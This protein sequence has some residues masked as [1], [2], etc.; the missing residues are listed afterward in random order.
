MKLNL[1]DIKIQNELTITFSLDMLHIISVHCQ[2]SVNSNNHYQK[3][4]DENDSFGVITI[5]LLRLIKR[6]ISYRK[7]NEVQ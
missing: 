3:L 1:L 2:I 5:L 6:P 7:T 4:N